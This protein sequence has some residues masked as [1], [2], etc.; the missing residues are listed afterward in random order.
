MKGVIASLAQICYH[1]KT[2]AHEQRGVRVSQHVGLV[3]AASLPRG[4]IQVKEQRQLVGSGQLA[5]SDRCFE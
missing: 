5:S 2:Q 4:V 1:S 3:N